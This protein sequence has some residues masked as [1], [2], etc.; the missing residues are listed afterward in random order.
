[1]CVCAL[2]SPRARPPSSDPHPPARRDSAHATYARMQL[3]SSTLVALV[4]AVAGFASSPTEELTSRSGYTGLDNIGPGTRAR[5]RTITCIYN[6]ISEDRVAPG[7]DSPLAPRKVAFTQAVRYGSCM[8][9]AEATRYVFP[10]EKWPRFEADEEV[11]LIVM[12]EPA[13]KGDTPVSDDGLFFGAGTYGWAD[14]IAY[15]VE[16][17]RGRINQMSSPSSPPPI[18]ASPPSPSAPGR[19]E[20]HYRRILSVLTATEGTPDPWTICDEN[21]VGAGNV[22]LAEELLMT[23][24]SAWSVDIANSAVVRLTVPGSLQCDFNHWLA[25][26]REQ[27]DALGVDASEGQTD[28]EHIEFL[29]HPSQPCPWGG[30]ACVGCTLSSTKLYSANLSPGYSGWMGVRMHELGHNFGLMHSFKNNV[31]YGDCTEVMGCGPTYS[32]PIRLLLGWVPPHAVVDGASLIGTG[33][34]RLRGANADPYDSPTE[35][36][37]TLCLSD[38]DDGPPGL[39]PRL[40]FWF[41]EDSYPSDQ[42][43]AI[44][45]HRTQTTLEPHTRTDVVERML[46]GDKVYARSFV[47]EFVEIVD[48]KAVVRIQA[49]PPAPPA[50]PPPPPTILGQCRAD[51]NAAGTCC[52]GTPGSENTASGCQLGSCLQACLLLRT[53]GS[54]YFGNKAE[55]LSFCEA[56]GCS[57]GGFSQCSQCDH[58]DGPGAPFGECSGNCND[59][60]ECAVGA[61]LD[62]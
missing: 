52:S 58:G 20:T 51:C 12:A 46:P 48:S 4:A 18:P 55:V 42:S 41:M 49:A 23:S 5:Q 45:A 16:V 39:G 7:A 26:L 13:S 44:I 9:A 21:C 40:A 17:V 1:V 32:P 10:E 62:D 36:E 33:T 38:D 25:V 14:Q 19:P 34:F 56:R 11:T 54:S 6:Q 2:E 28:F 57:L 15:I 24:Y 30:V 22:W 29:A 27:D 59:P 43:G 37:A 35:N 47:M 60:A 53:P 61:G 3:R 31:E 8:D 50:G